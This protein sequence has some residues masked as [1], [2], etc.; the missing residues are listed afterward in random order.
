MLK[1]TF[2]EKILNGESLVGI[3]ASL[4]SEIAAEVLGSSKID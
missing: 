3:F 1:N 4:G 2:K